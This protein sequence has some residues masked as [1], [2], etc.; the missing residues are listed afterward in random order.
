MAY[1]GSRFQSPLYVG[2][3]S[4]E[5]E[6]N[7]IKTFHLMELHFNDSSQSLLNSNLY[8]TDNFYS[9]DYDSATAP[10]SGSNT[11]Q[12]V[13]KFLTFGSVVEST[14]IKVN[15]ITVGL[16]GVDVADIS[17]VVHSNVVNKRVVIYRTFLDS[18]NAFQTNRTFLL[19]DGNIK[20]FNCVEGPEKSTITFSVATHWANFEGVNGR[21]TNTSTQ[22]YTKRY[23]STETFKHDKGF[24][25]SSIFVKD[26]HWGPNN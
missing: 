23:N 2:D 19:F 8:F 26:V 4:G 5:V 9:I 12:A 21:I 17:D 3:G 16:S 14:A 24:E 25:Y 15:A 10:D 18:N 11:Y 7:Q 1:T 22:F 6:K 13:G 20:N